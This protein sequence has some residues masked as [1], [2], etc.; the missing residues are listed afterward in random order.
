MPEIP[1]DFLSFTSRVALRLEAAPVDE[2]EERLL[3]L[4]TLAFT[5]WRGARAL[6]AK[7]RNENSPATSSGATV[8]AGRPERGAR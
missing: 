3:D 8:S 5:L 2:F 4:A 7:D 6:E 1:D